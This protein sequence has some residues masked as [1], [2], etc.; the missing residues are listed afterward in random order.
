MAPGRANR[1]ISGR[2]EAFCGFA[3]ER[4]DRFVTRFTP[5]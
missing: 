5:V 4:R 3:R 1:A 2:S